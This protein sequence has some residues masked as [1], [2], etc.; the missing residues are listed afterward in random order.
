MKPAG[1]ALR[2]A[3]YTRKSTEEG[4]DQDYNS[5]HAQRDACAAY[6]LSQAGEGW[7]LLPEVYDD[8]GYSGGTM[9]RPALKRLLADI[10]AGKIDVVVVYKVDRLTRALTDFSRIVDV[11]DRAGASFVSVTQAFNT[12][13]SMGRL[14]LNVLLSFAQFEREVT[15]ERIRDKIAASKKLGMWMGGNL[16]LG[17]DPQ[18][19]TL[20]INPDEA[21]L[22]RHIFRRYLEVGSVNVLA[23][24]LEAQGVRS[25]RWTTKAGTV[26]GGAVLA[27]GALLHILRN[28]LYLGEIPHKD[29]SHPGQHPAILDGELFD[30]VQRL[31]NRTIRKPRSDAKARTPTHAPL[32]GLIYDAAGNRMSPVQARSGSHTY[33]YY[34]STALQK[35]AARKAAANA[36]VPAAAIEDIVREG[37]GQ[38]RLPGLSADTPDWSAIR[39]YLVRVIIEAD[40]ISL[41]LNAQA[42]EAAS[43]IS[44]EAAQM[45]GISLDRS[46]DEPTL[47]LPMTIV[48]RRGQVLA[49]G[50]AG[51]SPREPTGIDPALSAA[52]I[53]AESWKRQLFAGEAKNVEAIG[54]AEGIRAA[55]V[56]KV[57]RV[58]FLAPDLKDAILQ[59]RQPDG[60]TL[61]AV[62]TRDLPLA[63]DEQRRLYSA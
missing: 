14:T 63:W 31:L 60:L 53:R 16:A 55:Y 5:L 56:A 24:E 30:A 18:G 26:R 9:D 49:I 29:V 50:P 19:R 17:Y 10:D 52:L 25:K 36:R 15:G 20:V 28:R 44:V 22:V 62:M 46:G 42:L 61:Q 34:V 13:T 43:K 4:L 59:G 2:C 39:D 21:E 45:L 37:L 3:I 41:A 57:L 8:G 11:L 1:R 12:T 7:T 32:T 58:A 27:R 48:R 35:G 38:L 47:R 51:T 54:A 6:I 40:V 23:E 33:R